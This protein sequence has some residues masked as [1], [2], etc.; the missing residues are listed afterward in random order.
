V[1][2][3]GGNLVEPGQPGGFLGWSK[4]KLQLAARVQ[5]IEALLL[6]PDECM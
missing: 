5:L 3:K 2:G 6:G 1:E 4:P